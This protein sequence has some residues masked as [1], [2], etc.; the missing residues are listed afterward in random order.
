MKL[1][2]TRPSPACYEV[3]VSRADFLA[4]MRKKKYGRYEPFA[5]R[6]YFAAPVRLIDKQELP[7]GWGLIW[8]GPK[9]WYVVKAP[10][11]EQMEPAAW[12]E[13]LL[14]AVLAHYPGPWVQP[15]RAARLG[16]IN[17]TAEHRRL[18]AASGG[19]FGKQVADVLRQTPGRTYV[20]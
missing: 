12:R 1:S 14:A 13:V 5:E 15:A 18:L 2:R 10:R 16:R 7:D 17:G 11:R 6:C 19:A 4:D 20:E 9:G 3:K 8:R